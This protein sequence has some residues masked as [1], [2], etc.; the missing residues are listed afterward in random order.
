M[1][2]HNSYF[3]N[4]AQFLNLN[5]TNEMSIVGEDDRLD[6]ENV[7]YNHRDESSDEQSE[8]GGKAIELLK[9]IFTPK[10]TGMKIN[11]HLRRN[12]LRRQSTTRIKENILFFKALQPESRNA[13]RTR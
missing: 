3:S 1:I 9:E 12:I 4:A 13:A 7:E 8:S 11:L 2:K 10:E 6:D 5:I